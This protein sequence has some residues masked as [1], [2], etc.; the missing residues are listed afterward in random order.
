MTQEQQ[1]RL[2]RL[3]RRCISMYFP[4]SSAGV[5][6]IRCHLLVFFP[7]RQRPYRLH[8]TR[9]PQQTNSILDAVMLRMENAKIFVDH[10]DES[11][12][13]RAGRWRWPRSFNDQS[14]HFDTFCPAPEEVLR[15]DAN[16][17]RLVRRSPLPTLPVGVL[18]RRGD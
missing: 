12:E 10:H 5:T 11:H 16:L 6:T 7:C 8:V 1:R 4:G 3:V 15:S 17:S 14:E 18:S 13:L 2:G 9:I